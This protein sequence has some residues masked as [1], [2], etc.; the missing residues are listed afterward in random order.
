MT[1]GEEETHRAEVRA[2]ATLSSVRGDAKGTT[3]AGACADEVGSAGRTN[4][5][6]CSLRLVVSNLD[7]SRNLADVD[8]LEMIT[9][10]LSI[11]CA[12]TIVYRTLVL[13]RP[14]YL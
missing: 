11:C 9:S 6:R 2:V 13:A 4:S 3:R 8:C 1:E 14:E 7:A 12:M 10:K 5:A